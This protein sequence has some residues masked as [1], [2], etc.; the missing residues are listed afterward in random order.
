MSNSLPLQAV[1]TQ[2]LADMKSLPD[3]GYFSC[4]W[5]VCNRALSMYG[6]GEPPD[7]ATLG[8]ETLS[9][10]L[11]AVQANVL[12]DREGVFQDLIIRW[13]RFIEAGLGSSGAMN[14]AFTLQDVC[15]EITGEAARFSA[16]SRMLRPF[17]DLPEFGYTP[18][19][20]R[21]FRVVSGQLVSKDSPIY[22][23]LANIHLAVLRLAEIQDPVRVMEEI[24]QWK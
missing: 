23:F 18:V 16:T 17:Q 13:D 1:I 5:I 22:M 14:I 9:R 10:L 11:T 20:G 8:Q 3:R 24:F 21:R 15:L 12:D 2:V 19:P 4:A 6:E 7:L